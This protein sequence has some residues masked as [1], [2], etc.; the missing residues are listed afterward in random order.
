MDVVEGSCVRNLVQDGEGKE[1]AW[2]IVVGGHREERETCGSA[3]K[4]RCSID[5]WDYLNR[6]CQYVKG[7]AGSTSEITY[8]MSPAHCNHI[9][10]HA[11]PDSSFLDSQMPTSQPRAMARNSVVVPPEESLV[12]V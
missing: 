1:E 5:R 12:A 6:Y 3:A 4:E 2:S 10:L 7:V 9:S 8:R 11:Q